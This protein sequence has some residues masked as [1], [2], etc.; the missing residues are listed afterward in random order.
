MLKYVKGKPIDFFPGDNTYCTDG[1]G[2]QLIDGSIFC[3][4]ITNWDVNANDS[5]TT[6]CNSA[7]TTPCAIDFNKPNMLIDVNGEKGPNK[8]TTDPK[9][10]KDQYQAMLYNNKLVPFGEAAQ[11]IFYEKNSNN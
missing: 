6:A 9:A 7:N 10:P 8:M 1:G 3:I 2:G 11:K 4:D 5:E